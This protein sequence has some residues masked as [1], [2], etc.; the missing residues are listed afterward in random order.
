MPQYNI[1]KE[2]E[3]YLV[4]S[5][6]RFRLDMSEISFGQSFETIELEEKTIQ[7]QNMFKPVI[8]DAANPANFNFTV[9]LIKEPDFKVVVDRALDCKTFDLFIVTKAETY[10]IRN[11]VVTNMVFNIGRDSLLSVSILG[12]A[13]ELSNGETLEGTEQVRSSTMRYN[14]PRSTD[15]VLNSVA[16]DKIRDLSIELQNEIS[17][18]P[19]DSIEDACAASND[20]LFPEEFTINKKILAGSITTYDIDEPTYNVNVPL[21]ITVTDYDGYGIDIDITNASFT[22]RPNTG[23]VF[24][25]SYDWRMTQNPSSLSEVIEYI[26]DDTDYPGAILDYWGNPILDFWGNALL[27]NL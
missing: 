11:C 12:Q 14:V 19:F 22:S 3:V 1:K 13:S 8:V 7:A 26:T 9:S 18:T 10:K 25:H 23:P 21:H 17:W 27:E 15:A 4:S 16:F 5:G 6:R 24:T 20:T 2:A